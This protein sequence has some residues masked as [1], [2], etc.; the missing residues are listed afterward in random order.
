MRPARFTFLGMALV[1]LV[2][3]AASAGLLLDD[4]RGLIGWKGTVRFEA[5]S[6]L[7]V[8]VEYNVYAPGPDF[9]TSCDELFGAGEDPSNGKQYVYAYQILNNVNPNPDPVKD[10]VTSF[11]VGLPDGDEQPANIGSVAVTGG[12]NPALKYFSPAAPAVPSTATWKFI[13]SM[14]YPGFS[15][16]LIYTSPYGPELDNATVG[17]YSFD[18]HSMPSPTPEPATLAL[19]A[20]GLAAVWTLR[21]RRH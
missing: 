10:Y 1:G 21:R 8:D 17:G 6:N 11:S 2:A 13:P 4:P 5:P 16:I 14:K 9:E 20:G 12:T 19:M 15:N 3:G 7:F 18:T